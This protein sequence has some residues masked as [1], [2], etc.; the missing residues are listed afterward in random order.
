[1]T[2]LR[3]L[4]VLPAAATG[5]YLGLLA[6]MFIYKLDEWL[7]P[8]RYLV[9]GFCGAPWSPWV[10]D[11]AFIFGSAVAACGVVCLPTPVAP[12][13]RRAVAVAAYLGGLGTAIGLLSRLV[14]LAGFQAIGRYGLPAGAAL[15]TGGLTLLFLVRRYG[16]GGTR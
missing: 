12:S 7:C 14:A 2:I 11:F 10:R 3:W 1:M 9:S 8:A 15:V 13:H 6:G 4:F 16:H 5:W